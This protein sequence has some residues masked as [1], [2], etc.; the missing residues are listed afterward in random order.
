[1]PF[2]VVT[3]LCVGL[4]SI[5]GICY[6]NLFHL[7]VSK[8]KVLNNSS[9]GGTV[10][11]N[12]IVLK[13]KKLAHRKY[14]AR[15]S[16]LEKYCAEH[17][18]SFALLQAESLPRNEGNYWKNRMFFDSEN[19]Y[20]WCC[21]YKVASSTMIAQMVTVAGHDWKTYRTSLE[22]KNIS[23]RDWRTFIPIDLFSVPGNSTSNEKLSLI[24]SLFDRVHVDK[25]SIAASVVSGI[26]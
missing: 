13:A 15:R 17:N 12:P 8:Q 14:V 16:R 10:D 18:S 24:P 6:C 19:G 3:S 11:I 23:A 7:G 1:M 20:M 9:L 25:R 2:K 5:F 22:D 26:C 4:G 21:N